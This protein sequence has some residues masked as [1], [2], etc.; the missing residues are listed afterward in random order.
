M[1]SQALTQ[2]STDGAVLRVRDIGKATRILVILTRES[3]IID[4]F[5]NGAR[6]PKSR[7]AAVAQPFAYSDFI[8]SLKKD[9]Y[10]VNTGEIKHSFYSLREDIDKLSIAFYFCELTMLLAPK[11]GTQCGSP[12]D[13]LRLFL[14]ALNFL[15]NGLRENNFLKAVYEL[16]LLSI[17]GYMPDLVCCAVCGAYE[18]ESGGYSF[19]PRRGRLVCSGCFEGTESDVSALHITSPVLSAM[20]H[21][22]YSDLEDLFNFQLSKEA[23]ELLGKVCEAYITEQ[24]ER[25]FTSLD[26]YKSLK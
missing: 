20:R 17:S 25:T 4:V 6:N 26:F 1:K 5:A 12:G 14:N 10:T 19:Y 22:I 21:I 16:R 13:Y 18:S 8:I 23:L 9:I 2:I 24:M 7:L 3:G 15:E 11:P